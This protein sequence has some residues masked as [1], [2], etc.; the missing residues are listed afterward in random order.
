MND[1]SRELSRQC[2]MALRDY[3][4]MGGE[5]VLNR[6]YGLARHAA[7][8]GLGVLDMARIHQEA[9]AAC[10]PPELLADDARKTLK[11]AETFLLETLSPFEVTHRGFR[12]AN[13]R[14]REL[15]ETLEQR[16]SQLADTNRELQSEI[17]EH[18][19]T[20]QA[21]R[22]SKE[23]YRDLFGQARVMEENMR[24]LSSRILHVQ[25]EERKRI[26]RELHD[27]VGQ[28]LTAIS[29]NLAM[30][31]TDALPGRNGLTK[32]LKDT[33]SLLEQMIETVHHF[34]REL[35]PAMLDDLGLLPTLRSYTRGFSTRTGIR[36]CFKASEIVER[37][38]SERKTVIYRIAQESLNNV[39]KHA[40]ARR[41]DVRIQ[42]LGAKVRLQI[43]DDGNGFQVQQHG[44]A[45]HE[46]TGQIGQWDVCR[47]FETGKR[48]GYPRRNSLQKM[49]EKV[50]DP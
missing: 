10:M 17:A 30:L 37:L 45:R 39:A 1:V 48:D 16:N 50:C 15:I 44:P 47:A 22:E 9:L 7:A 33:Q 38:D 34:A 25:E 4:A 24:Q 21:L 23:H 42:K 12:E 8:M 40:R 5:A 11:R 49:T 32:R 41:V 19:R 36:V 27:D 13:L 3:L 31:E 43:K 6:A 14:L 26:S 29:F 18:Q 35:R 2:I 28:V 20:E 46:G